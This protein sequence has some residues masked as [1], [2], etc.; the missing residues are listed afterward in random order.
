MRRPGVRR[1]RGSP[2]GSLQCG[3]PLL[4]ARAR[5][6]RFSANA[7]P[8]LWTPAN[9]AIHGRAVTGSVGVNPEPDPRC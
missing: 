7:N 8:C 1:S 6:D 4:Y 2:A 3:G 9:P 5:A